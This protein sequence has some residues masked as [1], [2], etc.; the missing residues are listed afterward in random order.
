MQPHEA[1]RC[2]WVLLGEGHPC[3]VVEKPA[4]SCWCWPQPEVC[5]SPGGSTTCL[6]AASRSSLTELVSDTMAGRPVP[7]WN[8]SDVGRLWEH[9]H[10]KWLPGVMAPL[11][12]G[13][14]SPQRENNKTETSCQWALASDG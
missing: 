4:S 2:G 11:Q 3:R 7:A 8:E 14:E 5:P 13:M 1:A 10:R 9:V 6:P 12:V